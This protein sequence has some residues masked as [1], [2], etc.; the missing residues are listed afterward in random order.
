M[1]YKEFENCTLCPRGCRVNRYKKTGY[2]GQGAEVKAARA[3]LHFW[4]EPC[5][6]GKNGSGAV[7][8]TGCQ[9]RCVFC[10]N[11]KIAAGQD[12]FPVSE[13]RLSEIFLE[14]QEKKANNINLVTPTHF[15]PV[16]IRAVEAARNQGLKI[17]IVYNTS[18]YEEVDTVKSLEG[19]VNVWL[20]DYKYASSV[21]AAKYSKA[22]DYPER[23][24][25]AIREMVR[26]AGAGGSPEASALQAGT[27]VLPSA[28]HAHFATA[29]E[30][31]ALGIEEGIMTRGVI[32]RHL[33]L[34][35]AVRESKD[36]L[37][38]L[39]DNFENRIFI[40]IMNQYTPVA[41]LALPDELTRKVAED[42]YDR[43]LSYA[44]ALGIENGFMQEGETQ[45]ESFIPEFTGEG[46]L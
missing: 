14:L 39:Y 21:L 34:P 44:N 3:A 27:G 1:I 5:I 20:P 17:P 16:I 32:V 45:K 11:T 12:G 18:A 22:P 4:E 8:F 25:A 2:C 42:E 15:V 13:S 30:A 19:I 46:I 6:S 35:G 36:A 26:Q 28:S 41:G 38:R 33:V 43:V 9:M 37:R 23:A 7:F 29:S 24:L 40:S 31:A 10:Q